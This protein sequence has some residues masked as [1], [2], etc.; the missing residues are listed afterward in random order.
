MV[1]ILGGAEG[2][3]KNPSRAPSPTQSLTPGSVLWPCDP[4]LNQNQESDAQPAVPPPGAL[5]PWFS[6]ED[7]ESLEGEWPFQVHMMSPGN[8]TTDSLN[9]FS[10]TSTLRLEC[11]W[12]C[13]L[14]HHLDLGVHP[15]ASQC[16]PLENQHAVIFPSQLGSCFACLTFVSLAS[17]ALSV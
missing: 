15:R 3:R 5:E 7:N 4:D 1:F 17:H 6:S 10:L 11:V 8:R 12:G 14:E 9:L 16:S 2:E 13:R